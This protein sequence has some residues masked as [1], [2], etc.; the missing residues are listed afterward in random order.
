MV[1]TMFAP[2][3]YEATALISVPN[4]CPHGIIIGE[5]YVGFM[6]LGDTNLFISKVTCG[7]CP[8]EA[9]P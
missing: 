9:T 5:P 2:R 6:G 7:Q 1:C 3:T 4:L 8:Q